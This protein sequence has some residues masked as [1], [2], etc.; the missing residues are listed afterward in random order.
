MQSFS[1]AHATTYGDQP[2]EHDGVACAVLALVEDELAVVPEVETPSSVSLVPADTEFAAFTP[3][4]YLAPQ[5]R[6]P[7]PRAPP[8]FL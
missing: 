2:H 5:T 6:A 7:P 8:I 4:Q 1:T 3:I